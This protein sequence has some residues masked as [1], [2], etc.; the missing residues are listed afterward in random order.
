MATWRPLTSSDIASLM[1]IANKIHATLPERPEVFAERITLYPAGCLALEQNNQLVG[2]AISHPIRRGQPPELDTLLSEI[3]ADADAY[4]IHDVAV[5]PELRGKGHAGDCVRL[6]L[7]MAVRFP[8][9]CLVSVYGTGAFWGRFGFSIVEVGEGL[10]EKLEGYGE[11]AIYLERLNKPSQ[12]R[13]TE[14]PLGKYPVRHSRG[15]YVTRSTPAILLVNRQITCEALEVLYNTEL[16]LKGTPATY[17]VF[18]QMDIAEFICETLLQRVRYAVL[19]LRS[20]EKLFVLSL[21]DIWGR[22]NDLKRLVV[23]LPGSQGQERN[24]AVVRERLRTFANV[25]GVPLDMRLIETN[26]ENA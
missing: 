13:R 15:F 26:P 23:Y 14:T 25:E 24:W 18:R 11:D 10:K 19:R 3:P 5:L 4:Y 16:I 20:P 22:E 2:Y 17:F 21:L 9:V 12:R 7:D 8:V 1:S 6:L